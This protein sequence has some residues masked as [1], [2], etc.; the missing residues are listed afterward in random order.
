MLAML[1]IFSLGFLAMLQYMWDVNCAQEIEAVM[2]DEL[3]SN[4]KP[5]EQDYW[6]KRQV[7][8]WTGISQPDQW[9]YG[10]ERAAWAYLPYVV[11][12]SQLWIALANLVMPVPEIWNHGQPWALGLVEELDADLVEDLEE[13]VVFWMD[14]KGPAY[15]RKAGNQTCQAFDLTP[16]ANTQMQPQPEEVTVHQATDKL[17][18]R[19]CQ[20]S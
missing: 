9:Q 16:M 15:L 12:A 18:G 6:V 4:T 1:T 19:Y 3:M 11:M 8:H 17:P 5:D 10:T 7:L 2:A 14:R 13:E 20:A